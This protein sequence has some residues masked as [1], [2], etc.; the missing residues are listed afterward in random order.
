MNRHDRRRDKAERRKL[1]V[2][3]LVHENNIQV[4]L[5]LSGNQQESLEIDGVLI[6]DAEVVDLQGDETIKLEAQCRD[7]TLIGCIIKPKQRDAILNQFKK[8]AAVHL[9]GLFSPTTFERHK[10]TDI[11]KPI[12]GIM[13]ITYGGVHARTSD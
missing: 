6:K 11:L 4:V 5:D 8:G 3:S 12:A 13:I 9:G 10:D 2:Q 1:D 7:L